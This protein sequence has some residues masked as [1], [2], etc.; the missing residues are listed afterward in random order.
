MYC[1]D[2]EALLCDLAETYGVFDFRAVPTKLLGTLA[3][4]LRK[5][6]RIKMKM[7]GLDEMR[8]LEILAHIADELKLLRHFMTA[9]SKNDPVPVLFTDR[10]ILQEAKSEQVGLRAARHLWRL[11]IN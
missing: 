5:D 8:W 6:S 11:G 7:A 10:M 3:V 2:R 9:Q 1:T 4:G